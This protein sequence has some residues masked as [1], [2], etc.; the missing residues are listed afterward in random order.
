MYPLVFEFT[1]INHTYIVFISLVPFGDNL[2]MCVWP[3][4]ERLSKSRI[5]ELGSF[6]GEVY[7]FLVW[8]MFSLVTQHISFQLNAILSP[9]FLWVTFM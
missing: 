1:S 9:N 8:S 4:N 7:K 3:T 6:E 5:T 2:G